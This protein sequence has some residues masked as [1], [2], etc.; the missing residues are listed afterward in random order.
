MKAWKEYSIQEKRM[1]IVIGVLLLAVFL[2]FGR[3]CQ[4]FKKGFKFF[5]S[6]EKVNVRDSL[7]QEQ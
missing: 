3:V 2:S 5:Y 4:G 7:K 1:I 6:T